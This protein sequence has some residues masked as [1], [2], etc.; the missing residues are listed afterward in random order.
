[1]ATDF[2]RASE[3]PREAPKRWILDL[4]VISAA[5]ALQIPL[6]GGIVI[7]P[8]GGPL[9]GHDSGMRRR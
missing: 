9:M 8:R 4:A 5:A 6:S 2:R 7:Q 3:L 1:M